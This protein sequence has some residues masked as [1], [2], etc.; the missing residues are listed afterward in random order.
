MR[1]RAL[2]LERQQ[3]TRSAIGK[4]SQSAGESCEA[5]VAKLNETIAKAEPGDSI[6]LFIAGHG[7]QAADRNLYLAQFFIAK[8]NVSPL[9]ST[10]LRLRKHLSE[11]I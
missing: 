6:L 7:V 11:R 2:G 5:L 10:K 3:H 8:P 1:R 4:I 9:G